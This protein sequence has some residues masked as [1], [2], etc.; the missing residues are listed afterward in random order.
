M[1]YSQNGLS[2]S[3][4]QKDFSK[5]TKSELILNNGIVQ[6]I[7]KLPSDTGSFLTTSYGP[8]IGKFHYFSPQNIDFQ[9]EIDGR[10]YSGKTNWNLVQIRTITDDLQGNGAAVILQST[11][12]KIE[13]T[14]NFLMYPG[15]PVVRKYLAVK[16]ISKEEISLESVDVEKLNFAN[17]YPSTYSWIYGDYGRRKSIGPYEG[18]MQD[19]LLIIHDSDKEAGIIVGNEASGVLKRTS[20]FWNAQDLCTGLTHKDARFP[21]RKWIKTGESFET[22]K[23]FTMV[24]RS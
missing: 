13:L 17:Y 12:K 6:R 24:L 22:P 3:Y 10:I 23:V 5:W 7:I 4:P 18:N 16:N 8:V 11:D 14:V 2:N 19:A 15:L 1:A 21:F 9:F 20:V